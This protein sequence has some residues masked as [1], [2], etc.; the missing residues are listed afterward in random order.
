MIDLAGA[1]DQTI[2]QQSNPPRVEESI[3]H[4]PGRV[5][6]ENQP[7]KITDVPDSVRNELNQLPK[8]MQ[9]TT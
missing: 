2:K 9:L 5:G 1:T 7:R 6:R 8:Q 4:K 3:R